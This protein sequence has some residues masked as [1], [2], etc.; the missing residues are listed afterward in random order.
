M[1]TVSIPTYRTSPPLLERAVGSVLAQTHRDLRLVV[2]N[3]GGPPLDLDDA[4]DRLEILDLPDNRGRYFADAVVL[5]AT[6][7][8]WFAVHDADDWSEPEAYAE[9]IEIARQHAG[10]AMAPFWRHERGRTEVVQHP[11]RLDPDPQF[12]HIGHWNA[13]VTAVERLRAAGGIHA[14]FRLGYDTLVGL[15]LTIT[16]P[17]GVAERPRWHWVRRPGSLTR[18]RSTRLGSRER[19]HVKSRLHGLWGAAWDAWRAGGRPGE[20]IAGDVDPGTAVQVDRWASVLRGEDPG[21]DASDTVVTVLTGRRPSLLEGMLASTRDHH[22]GLLDTAHVEVLVNGGDTETR[23]VVERHADA[24]DRVQATE[25]LEPIGSAM[26]L[27][28]ERAVASGRRFWIHLEDDWEA[29]PADGAW[30]DVA[31]A[32]LDGDEHVGQVRLRRDDNRVLSRHMV[33]GRPL[34]WEDRA[35]WRRTGDAHLTFNPSLLRTS[36]IGRAWPCDSE[37][38][39]QARWHD[40]GP[41]AVGQLMPGVWTHAGEGRSLRLEVGAAAA[42]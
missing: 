4:D 22:P 25:D 40:S 35:G 34:R 2:V 9:L 18:A 33:T 8:G 26:S 39:A 36:D 37:R 42:G 41:R 11:R 12:R 15:M 10:A 3:D 13:Q 29:L 27:L 17:V 1:L 14:G 31:R 19:H 7:G 24:V 16:G 28:A 20:V 23:H 30:L 6:D 5:A 21:L 32:V 38:H